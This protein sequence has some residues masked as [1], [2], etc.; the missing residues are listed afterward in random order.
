MML[1]LTLPVRQTI[2]RLKAT[3]SAEGKIEIVAPQLLAGEDVEI[4][5]LLPEPSEVER[6]SA[7][8]ILAEASG[9]RQ[10]KTAEEVDAYL[11][12]EHRAWE[13]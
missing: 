7:L 8:D 6:R 2:L 3:V 11:Q 5:I 12:E 10:F 13:R 4:L 1:E 9:Q